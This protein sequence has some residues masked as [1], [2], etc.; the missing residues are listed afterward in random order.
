MMEW[1]WRV[2]GNPGSLS[3]RCWLLYNIPGITC[4]SGSITVRHWS[5]FRA[6]RQTSVSRPEMMLCDHV[7]VTLSWAGPGALNQVDTYVLN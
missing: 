4:D 6:W 3:G 1:W 7:L 2:R 5:V